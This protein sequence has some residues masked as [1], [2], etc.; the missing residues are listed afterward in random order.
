MGP[1]IKFLPGA[2]WDFWDHYLPL[3][4]ESLREALE[5]RGF[6]IEKCVG[7]FLPY[8]MTK[9]PR[10]PLFFLRMYLRLPLAWRILGKQFLVVA[11]KQG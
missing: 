9:G 4:E 10:Y 11:T 5:N 1:N 2:Y 8:R 3:T 6:E 7:K